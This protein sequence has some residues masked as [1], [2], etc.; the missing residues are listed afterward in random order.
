MYK[1]YLVNDSISN[2]PYLGDLI[3]SINSN[4]SSIIDWLFN[5]RDDSEKKISINL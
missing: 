1:V 3:H 4:V 5:N 2:I